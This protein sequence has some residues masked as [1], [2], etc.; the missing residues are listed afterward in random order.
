[1]VLTI[2]DKVSYWEHEIWE[3]NKN[4]LYRVKELKQKVVDWTITAEEKE[5]LNLIK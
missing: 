4:I 1:M 5:E 3:Y 2:W